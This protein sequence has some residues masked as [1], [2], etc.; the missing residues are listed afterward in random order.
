MSVTPPRPVVVGYDGSPASR[1]AL[2][3]AAAYADTA[4]RP[5]RLLHALAVP[6]VSS[7]MGVTGALPVDDLIDAA[8]GLLDEACRE[9]RKTRPDLDVDVVVELGP[10]APVLVDES[11]QASLTVLGSRGLGEFRDVVLGSA[12]AQVATHATSPVVVV[13]A[14]SPAP[15]PGGRVVVGVDGSELSSAAVDFAFGYAAVTG[16]SIDAVLAWTGP[17]STGPGD[18]IPLVYDAESLRREDEVVLAEAVAGRSGTYP[19]VV[20]RERVVHGHPA[21]VLLDAADGAQLLVVGSRGRGGFRGLL[22]GSVSRA[23]LHRSRCP[24]A[25]VR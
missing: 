10:A 4:A 11:R 6:L 25:V 12:A 7:P 5:L 17:V 16:A 13:P 24:V 15:S 20:M 14:G 9:V 8:R 2:E 21:A 3:W 19:D 1:A 22:L 23:V 18:M